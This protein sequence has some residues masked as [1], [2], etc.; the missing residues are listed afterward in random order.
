MS[1]LSRREILLRIVEGELIITN[2]DNI[3]EFWEQEVSEEQLKKIK[4]YNQKFSEIKEKIENLKC[5]SDFEENF[6]R[7]NKYKQYFNEYYGFIEKGNLNKI[8][9]KIIHNEIEKYSKQTIKEKIDKRLPIFIDNI[10]FDNI[11]P[12]NIDLKL[13]QEVFTT[14]QEYPIKLGTHNHGNT[15][16]IEPGAFGVFL[17][18]ESIYIPDDLLGLIS[19]RVTY[20]MKGLVNVS[21]FHVDP[22]YHGKILFAVYNTG[23]RDIYLK[24]GEPIFMITFDKLD[25]PTLVGYEAEKIGRKHFK[26]IPA[27]V[28]TD[29]KG[30]P[31][32]IKNLDERVKILETQRNIYGTILA[33]LLVAVIVLILRVFISGGGQQ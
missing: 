26:D 25:E 33:A 12:A 19:L 14:S 32:S 11:K 22:G 21:G 13:G 10:E 18:Q 30:A 28:V 5:Y 2:D 23:P 4:E 8:R 1:V 15:I 31:V 9:E 16:K 24:L 29:L 27:Y 20:K 17:T 3:R 7:N 6:K